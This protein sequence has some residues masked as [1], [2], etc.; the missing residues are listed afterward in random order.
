MPVCFILS[1]KRELKVCILLEISV[2]VTILKTHFL[3]NLAIFYCLN[4]VYWNGGILVFLINTLDLSIRKQMFNKAAKLACFWSFFGRLYPYW[5][6][7]KDAKGA[8]SAKSISIGDIS[9]NSISAK[10]IS[11]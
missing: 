11:V 1:T 2:L 8:K 5:T 4:T 7:A 6:W 10:D 3:S 9:I